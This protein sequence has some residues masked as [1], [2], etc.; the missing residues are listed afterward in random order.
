M[1]PPRRQIHAHPGIVV[2]DLIGALAHFRQARARALANDG[3][4]ARAAYRAFLDLW[5]NADADLPILA[6]AK[7]GL[8]TLA[9][10]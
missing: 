10:R 5:K 9:G 7:A 8:S 1:A 2:S 6:D 4:G 3:A